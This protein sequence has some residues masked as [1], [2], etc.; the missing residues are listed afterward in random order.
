VLIVSI[1]ILNDGRTVIFFFFPMTDKEDNNN[2]KMMEEKEDVEKDPVVVSTDASSFVPATTTTTTTTSRKRKAEQMT[3]ETTNERTIIDPNEKESTTRIDV[4]D[5]KEKETKEDSRTNDSSTT[6]VETSV[7]TA[8]VVDAANAAAIVVGN[9]ECDTT[10]DIPMNE[11]LNHDNN[12]SSVCISS[13]PLSPGKTMRKHNVDAMKMMMMMQ[14]NN[15]DDENNAASSEMTMM[16]NR[17]NYMSLRWITVTNDGRPE[18]MVK[19]IGLKSLFAKQ[20]PKMP[21]PYIARLVLDR[22]HTS[23]A[24][25]SDHPAVQGS[26]EEIIG[27]ICYRAFPEMKFAEIAF[28]AVNSSH[29]VK[30]YGTKLMNLLKQT[31]A[32]TG[33]EFFITYAD[34]YAIGYFKKQGFTKNITMPKGR[35]F[36]LIKD[37]DGGTPMECYVHPS[38]DFTR[39]PEMIQA[40]R[41]YILRCIAC[42]ARSNTHVYPPLPS[43]FE[44]IPESTSGGGV[45][46]SNWTAAKAYSI[47]G[48]AEAGWTMTDLIQSMNA[49]S[50]KD[51]QQQKSALKSDLLAIVRKVEEQQFAWPFREPVDTNEVPDY[52]EVIKEP[53]DLQT[54]SKRIRQDNYYKSKQMLFADLMLMV[55]NC[56][57]YNDE[58]SMYTQC[59]VSLENFV[60]NLMQDSVVGLGKTGS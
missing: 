23:L 43:N 5:S 6:K 44:A 15:N 29:Q 58:G 49:A 47:P 9:A 24:I 48:V 12:K 26:D 45:S 38:I 40:Q 57:L 31:A 22:R 46:R 8:V 41:E 51:A 19:L 28:C 42:T 36:G 13:P 2:Q 33:I 10:T 37:Y 39:V 27:G 50:G 56:K 17:T 52:L 55:N 4:V 53:I 16:Q 20:L 34:N 60:K 35:Y 54:M 18:S 59:A 3:S 14:G 7:S 11:T 30:G 25:L 21:K 1:S 32:R